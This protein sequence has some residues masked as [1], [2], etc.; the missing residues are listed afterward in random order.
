MSERER[1]VQHPQ[2]QAHRRGHPAPRLRSAGYDWPQ[3]RIDANGNLLPTA[4]QPQAG[5]LPQ[6]FCAFPKHS[7]R[8]SN[9][10][11]FTATYNDFDYTGAIWRLEEGLSTDE[12][13]NRYPKGYGV[14][15]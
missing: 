8:P 2:D 3:R 11:G 4:K 14:E 1:E 15:G 12:Y 13:M 10:I 6:T 7:I 5:R 9:T